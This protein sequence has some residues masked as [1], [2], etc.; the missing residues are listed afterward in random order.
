MFNHRVDF[1]A[2]PW[3]S[4]IASLR[5]TAW[6]IILLALCWL[7]LVSPA[8][9]QQPASAPPS[10]PIRAWWAMDETAIEDLDR[11]EEFGLNLVVIQNDSE[12]SWNEVIDRLAMYDFSD[13]YH[14]QGAARETSER[15]RQRYRAITAKARKHGVDCYVQCSEPYAPNGLQPVTLDNPELW[16]LTGRRL[17]EVF[18]AL[19]DLAGYMLYMTE[20]QIE[21][22]TVPGSETSKTRRVHRLIETV[23]E[24]CR[25]EHRKLIV[26]T[27]IHNLPMLEA[28]A[29]VLRALPADPDFAVMQYCCPNDWGLY[30]L[31]N[32]SLGRV[33][34]H[35]EILAFDYAAE[36]WGQG[37]YPF[38]HVDFMVRRLR[39][40]R[41]RSRNIAGLAGYVS[42]YGRRSL[43]SFNEANIYAGTALTRSPD[44]DG[45]D[46]LHE[47]CAKRFG[48]KGADV[49]AAC[50]ARTHDVVFKSQHVFGYW[51]DTGNKSGL[52]TLSELDEYFIKDYWG[53]ALARWDRRF[54]PVWEKIQSPDEQ[55]LSEVLKEKEEAIA[56][57]QQSIEQVQ[58]ARNRFKPE[59]LADL[60]RA[61][62][63]QELW[64]R[65]WRDQ[66]EAFFLRQIARKHGQSDQLRS[67]LNKALDTLSSDADQLEARYGRDAFPHGP[68]RAREFVEDVRKELSPTTGLAPAK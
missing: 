36:N 9:P 13:R 38:V 58:S 43:G 23:W 1:A 48:E 68:G 31:I 4:P 3:G 37:V 11:A 8:F 50:L 28:I 64:A 32:P 6:S 54:M 52:P 5:M 41:A 51:L 61:F 29:E 17:R 14:K 53:E 25:A 66:V 15:F 39:E 33:G 20:G 10:L 18:Q 26:A 34:P 19:P 16:E 62:A 63:F 57:C 22:E 24:A 59:D 45:A 65:T 27:F 12:G 21:I 44:R 55:F 47:W 49:A 30:E 42:W 67:R 2:V 40:A 56:L 46:I 35:P 7:P 60:E